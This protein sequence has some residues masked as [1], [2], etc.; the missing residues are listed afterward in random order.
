MSSSGSLCNDSP[1]IGDRGRLLVV[2]DNEDNRII[3]LRMFRSR[4][5]EA[6]GAGS[7]AQALQL[8]REQEFDLILLDWMMPDMDG[9]EV[10]KQIR[11]KFTANEL[12]VMMVT[13]KAGGDDVAMAIAAGAN[14]YVAKPVD[15]ARALA[16]VATLIKRKRSG[17]ELDL[18]N[19]VEI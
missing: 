19:E 6:T 12:P 17:G 4:G 3:L 7:G 18:R 5:F 2:D 14:D 9:L 16:G 8:I 13:A 10:L 15:F 11:T 1:I